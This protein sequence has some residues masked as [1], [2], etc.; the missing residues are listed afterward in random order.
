MTLYLQYKEINDLLY[1][2]IRD[3]KEI[4]SREDDS[5]LDQLIK[6][7]KRFKAQYPKYLYRVTWEIHIKEELLRI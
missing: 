2:N 6:K 7:A 1:K 3:W 5:E 4:T